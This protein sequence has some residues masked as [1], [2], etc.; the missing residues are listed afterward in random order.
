MAKEERLLASDIGATSIK[1]CE[2][3][4]AGEDGFALSRFAH[5]EYEEELSEGTRMGVVAGLL[6]QMLAEG[7]FTARRALICMSGQ[8]SLMRFTRLPTGSFDRKQIR[9]MA[10]FDA[11]KNIPFDIK[12][13]LMDYQLIQSPNDGTVD[14]M[15]IVI[16]ND[17]VE[18]FTSAITQ[19]GCIPLLI[20]VAP[21]ADYNAA[22]ACGLGAEQCDM[23]LNIGGRVTNLIFTEG[24]RYYARTIPIAG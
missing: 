23:L 1:L 3:N 10:E 21:A 7:G 20:D 8:S 15:S 16:K 13:V 5:R 12:E 17:I 18:Q 14:I 22:R 4:F 19:V 24:D 9:Q 6:R 2:F 11:T